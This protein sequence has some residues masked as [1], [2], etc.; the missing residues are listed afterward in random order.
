VERDEHLWVWTGEEVPEEPPFHFP[1]YGEQ[2]WTSFFMHTRFGAP[3]EECVENF[4][5]V[6]HTIFAHPGLFRGS[7]TRPVR[8]RVTRHRD[9]VAAEFL[10]EPELKGF[11]PRLVFPRGTVMTHTDRFILPSITRVDYAFGDAYRFVITSQCTQ[12][13]EFVVDVTTAITWRLPLPGV[14]L[15]PFLRPY[16]RHVIQQDVD[17]LAVQGDQLKRFGRAHMSTA[18]DLLGRHIW[19]LRRWARDREQGGA[20]LT[21]EVT[22][23]I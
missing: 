4:L 1:Y 6:P 8:A 5:D 16:C 20:E 18:A 19:A 7:T 11:G 21:E 17:V 15:L 22:L 9:S 3:V 2:G 12:R 14:L 23:R 10:D 13:E